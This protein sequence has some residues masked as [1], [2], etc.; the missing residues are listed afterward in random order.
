MTD[1]ARQAQLKLA[2]VE[3]H[4]A[5]E[6]IAFGYGMRIVREAIQ[7]AL[8]SIR[9]ASWDVAASRRAGREV[10]NYDIPRVMVSGDIDLL[11]RVASDLRG[12]RRRDRTS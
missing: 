11:G 8:A 10:R 1:G 4:T 7:R 2:E 12:H 5:L 6:A 9:L 3:M